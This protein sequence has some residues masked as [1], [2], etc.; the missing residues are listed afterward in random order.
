MRFAQP[1]YLLFLL[2]IPVFW[3]SWSKRMRPA[4]VRLS[5]LQGAAFPVAGGWR[6]QRWGLVLRAVVFALWVIALARPQNTFRVVSRNVQG[7]DIMMVLDFSQSMN[8]ED[9]A[10][11]SRMAVAKDTMEKFVRGRS[12]DRI[13]LTI[14]SGEALALA[15][16]T[17]DY[18]L[19]L[20]AMKDAQIGVLRDGTAIGDG[21][22]VAVS[23]LRQSKAKSKVIVLLTDGENNVGRV[24]PATAGELA[25]GYGIKVYT[26]A[27]GREGRVR[28]PISQR[29]MF[30]NEIKTYQYFENQLNPELLQ[31]IAK[32]THGKFF[33]ATDEQALR[34]VF[35]EIDRLEKTDQKTQEKVRY[36]EEF[37]RPLLLGCVLAI[38]LLVLELFGRRT[39]L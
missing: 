24:D 31:I 23:H 21:L 16:P 25:A 19:V 3:R 2:L 35:A 39:L 20:R 17:L 22:A 37:D 14:F 8:A 15:P 9:L 7:I 27:V 6:W 26:I 34:D 18:A 38:L 11:R 29:G 1:I 32:T 13:G 10:D 30:G 36:E 12:N 5:V 28:V 33:R 4:A